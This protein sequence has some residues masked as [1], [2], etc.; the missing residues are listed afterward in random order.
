M[1]REFTKAIKAQAFQRAN[2]KCEGCH[3]KLS[4][5]KYAYDHDNP[6][7]LTGE[8]NLDNCRV[9]CLSCHSRKTRADVA[10]I[11]RA[12]RVQARHIGAHVSRTPL[13][14]GKQSKWKKKMDGSV[15]LR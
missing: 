4:V 15:V 14:C 9:L 12:K 5:G 7:G 8:P 2:G 11:A 10:T 6:D 13:P 3:A 1:R